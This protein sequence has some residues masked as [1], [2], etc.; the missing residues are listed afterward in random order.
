[1]EWISM[2]STKGEYNRPEKGKAVLVYFSNGY[3]CTAYRTYD[4]DDEPVWKVLFDDPE[5]KDMGIIT[6]WMPLPLP[7]TKQ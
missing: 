1:M 6:H 5:Y 4:K 3:I 7:P 2:K